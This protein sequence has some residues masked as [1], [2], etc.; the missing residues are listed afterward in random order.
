MKRSIDLGGAAAVLVGGAAGA[1]GGALLAGGTAVFL[2]WAAGET[3]A[4][5]QADAE[6]AN[7]VMPWAYTLNDPPPDD[8]PPPP[9]PDEVLT[10]PGS[11]VT[12]RRSELRDLFNPPDWH[13]DNHPPMPPVV[14]RGRQPDVRACGFCHLPNGQGRPEN[15]SVAGQ[16]AEYIVQ[17]MRDYRNGLRRSGEPRMGPPSLM[18]TIGLAAT[19]E[20]AQEAA[21]YFSSFPF[22]PWIRVVETDTVPV[23]RISGWMHVPVEGGGMEP[24]GT[25]IIETPEDV[26]RTQ[27][28]D[29]EAS[30]IAYVPA[31][32][33]ARGEALVTTGGNGRTETCGVC[34]GADLRGLGPVPHLAGRSPSYIARQLYDFQTGTR[35]GA[36]SD[37]MDAAVANLTVA[38][39]VD[40]AAYTASLEP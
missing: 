15:S 33:V 7:A 35:N 16:P 38:E 9:D 6:G 14:A 21:E 27:I 40:I 4:A 8:A 12:F 25:R 3:L 37:L 19:E 10:V 29:S 28:R 5:Q 36:W 13:P 26:G 24:I 22:R 30:F 1:V 17:Q 32:S 18:V 2:N 39:I 20:E 11:D 31:G 34:H 23:T